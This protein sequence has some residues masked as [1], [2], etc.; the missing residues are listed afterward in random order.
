MQNNIVTAAFGSFREARTRKIWQ[1]D[2]GMRLQFVG[3]ELPASYTVHQAN[4]PLS[5]N[6]KTRIGDETGVDI[7]DEYL[8]TG[9][10]VYVWL[11]LHTG[12][13]D[14][15]TVYMVTIPVQQRPKPVEDPPTPVQQG[16]I[17][18][19]IATL[20]DAVEQTGE[21]AAAAEASAERAEQA[22]NT[23]GYVDF[24]INAEGHLIY[25]KTPA[26]DVDFAL[27]DGHLVMEV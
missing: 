5:G 9:K 18:Q 21:D 15:E 22:A 8:T 26:V 25:T 2:Y 4:E 20:N 7:L 27:V 11:Y 6:A 19:A 23:A 24:E 14:G 17:E 13:A 16:L 10:N 1:W 3:L 12:D